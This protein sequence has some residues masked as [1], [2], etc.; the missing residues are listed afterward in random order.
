MAIVNRNMR[1]L[2]AAAFLGVSVIALSANPSLA[3]TTPAP[4]PSTPLTPAEIAAQNRAEDA[5]F[6]AFVANF[7][8]TAIKAGVSADTYDKCMA[9]ITRNAR[10]EQLNLQQPEFARP[11]WEYID[12]AVSPDRVSHGQQKLAQFAGPLAAIEQKYSAPKEILVAIW[13]I[14]SN[15]GEAMGSF[16]MFEALAT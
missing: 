8:D 7:R 2:A 14:E 1:V 12:S 9:G 16:N 10:V 13:G 4:T 5:K 15:Y 6:Q 3:Q 11:V